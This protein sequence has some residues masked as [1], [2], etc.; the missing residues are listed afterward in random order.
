MSIYK[1][2]IFD[3][4]GV[5][6]SSPVEKFTAYE[7]ANKL[8]KNFLGNVIKQNHHTNAWAKFERSEI[9]RQQFDKDFAAETLEQGHQ[10]K[11]NTLLS[12]LTLE[13]KPEMIKAHKRIRASGLKTGCITNNIPNMDSAKMLNSPQSGK[14]ANEILTSFDSVI[15]SSKAGVRKPEPSIY[16]MMCGQLN[17]DPSVCIFLDDLGINLKPARALGMTTIKVPLYDVNPAIQELYAL[18]DLMD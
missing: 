5:F 3:F 12:L 2:V 14:L 18:L 7:V 8:P 16:Q 13:L 15:E 1:A 6:T 4:G 11:G 17:V 9:S 10:I